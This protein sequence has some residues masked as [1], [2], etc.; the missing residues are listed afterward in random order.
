M[1]KRIIQCPD[2]GSEDVAL[3]GYEDGGGDEGDELSPVYECFDCGHTFGIDETEKL[4][5][6]D[7]E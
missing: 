5:E 6:D 1:L 3:N 2:C 7:E 4:Y